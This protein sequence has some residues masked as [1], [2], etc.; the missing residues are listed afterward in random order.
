MARFH[1]SPQRALTSEG[2]VVHPRSVKQA[3]LA[4]RVEDVSQAAIVMRL[5]GFVHWGSDYDESKATTPNGPLAQGFETA[6]HGRLFY[7]RGRETF[8]RFDVVAPGEV[9]GRWGDANNRSMYVE[10]P[11]RAPVG[12]AFELATGHSPTDRL[13]PGGNSRYLSEAWGYFSTAQ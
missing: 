10:R 5:T 8:T 1:L 9:W 11:G 4:L 12:F 2:R 13:P 7:D 3:R 6:L